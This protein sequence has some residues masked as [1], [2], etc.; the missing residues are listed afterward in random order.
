MT[1][2]PRPSEAGALLAAFDSYLARQGRSPG[3]R[4]KYGEALASYTDALER[5][6]T[7]VSAD[8]I[9]RYLDDWRE[10]FTARRGRAP[11][12]ASYRA[13]INALRAFYGYLDRFD[14]ITDANGNMRPD[15]MRKILPPRSEPT[16]NDWLRPAEDHALLRC[17]GNLQ[18]RFLVALLRWSGIRIGEATNLTRSDIDLTPDNQ[19]LTIRQS[20][21]PAGR[22]TIPI[23]PE[24][25]PLLQEWLEH[26][27]R[28]Q[29]GG[30]SVPLLASR[31]GSPMRASFGWRLVKRVA[32]RAGVRPRP[33]TCNTLRPPHQPGCPRNLNGYNTSDVSPHTLRRT[34]GS[35]LLNNGL[36]LEVVSKLLGH[37]TTTITEQAYAELLDDTTR[38][39]LLH[40]LKQTTAAA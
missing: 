1:T 26:L 4:R 8:D 2:S 35:H 20:K 36:R 15:P 29:L 18:E 10:Q 27:D 24:L 5:S 34:F 30:P 39:E 3:T 6:P 28:H 9:D 33:C 12:T 16:S 31:G 13:Q 19:A 11:A 40:A 17:D 14:L 21:T 38:R 25:Q 7:L 37:S 32:Y 23:L 22:R